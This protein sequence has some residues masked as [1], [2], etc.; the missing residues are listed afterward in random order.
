MQ[1]AGC[2]GGAAGARVCVCSGCKGEHGSARGST[3]VRG[4][5]GRGHLLAHGGCRCGEE[6]DHGGDCARCDG[7]LEPGQR[8]HHAAQGGE[9]R[10]LQSLHLARCRGYELLD[11]ARRDEGGA[12]WD[13]PA[14]LDHG[15]EAV[16]PHLLL[17]LLVAVAQLE[18]QRDGR[19][20][21]EQ[22]RP[23]V[24]LPCEPRQ[25]TGCQLAHLVRV[26]E[27]VRARVRT[28]VKNWG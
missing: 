1:G 23:P 21:L 27:K 7:L 17:L 5:W 12:A 13:V 2:K 10:G 20:G 19:V 3:A 6:G 15:G 18:Q 11:A 9:G 4:A 25:G 16:A 8:H 24:G 26:R 14:Q 28:R 22:A